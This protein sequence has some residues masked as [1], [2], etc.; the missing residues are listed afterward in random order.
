MAVP[1]YGSEAFAEQLLLFMTNAWAVGR[2]FGQRNPAAQVA[3]RVLTGATAEP[4]AGRAAPRATPFGLDR[5]LLAG[6]TST[7]RGTARRHVER[8]RATCARGM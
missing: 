3:A 6:L 1:A 7:R 5:T 4:G 8:R 2:I